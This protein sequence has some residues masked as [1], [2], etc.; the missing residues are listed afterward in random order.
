MALAMSPNTSWEH[1]PFS[2]PLIA[3]HESRHPLDYAVSGVL[4]L[5]LGAGLCWPAFRLTAASIA[6]SIASAVVWVALGIWAAT[7]ASC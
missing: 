2:G 6:L 3:L 4:L 5:G 7:I 1:H